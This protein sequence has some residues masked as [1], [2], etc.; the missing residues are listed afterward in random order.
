MD[1]NGKRVQRGGVSKDKDR[2]KKDCGDLESVKTG[3]SSVDTKVLCTFN[4]GHFA[5]LITYSYVYSEY[6]DDFDTR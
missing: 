3:R 1:V 2:L 6:D 4:S 5:S